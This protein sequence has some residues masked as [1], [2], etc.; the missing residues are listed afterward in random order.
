[1]TGVVPNYSSASIP[2]RPRVTLTTPNAKCTHEVA[3]LPQTFSTQRGWSFKAQA[4]SPNTDAIHVI[5]CVTI[6]L[7][8]PIPNTFPVSS[9]FNSEI[10]MD[11]ALSASSNCVVCHSTRSLKKCARCKTTEYCSLECQRA[12]WPSHKTA[13]QRPNVWYDVYRRCEDG[14]NHEGRLELITWSTSAA[15]A[16]GWEM[17]WGNCLAEESKALKKK[18]EEQ[19]AGDEEAFYEYWSQGFRW[20]CCGTSG[21]QSYGCDHHGRGT[22]P[23]SCDF[24]HVSIA[25]FAMDLAVNYV[26]T[27]TLTGR[28]DGQAV[29]GGYI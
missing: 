26:G 2:V 7:Q 16:E 23:C 28:V 18:F 5:L 24:C 22:R 19:Y 27:I 3:S 11:S 29:A 1:M 21:D 25:H 20:T 17:G 14:G 6:L 12:D 10:I 8:L 9:R 13:C 4:S 15:D